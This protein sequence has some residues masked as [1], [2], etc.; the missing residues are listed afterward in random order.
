MR[1]RLL[2]LGLVAWAALG[3]TVSVER[4]RADIAFLSS[5][6][7]QGRRALERGSDVAVQFLAA[8]FAKA[9]LKP[10]ADSLLQQFELVEYRTD[11][12]ATRLTLDQGG[13]KR[14]Y[15]YG[16]GITGGFPQAVTAAGPVVFAGYGITA[17]EYGYDDY[18]GLDAGGKLALVFEYEPRMHDPR[19][20]FNGTGNTRHASPRAKVLNAQAHGAVGLL[21][22]PAPNRKRPAAPAR[23]TR[24]PRSTGGA[25]ALAESEIRIP[26]FNLSAELAE[27]L[28]APAG[29]KPAEVQAAIDETLRPVRLDLGGARAEMRVA[30]AGSRRGAS[31]NVIGMIEGSDPRLREETVLFCAHYDHNG[32]RDGK[33]LPGADDNASGAAGL[34]ELARLFGAERARPR[35]TLLFAAFGA[36]EAGLLGSYY[37]TARPPRPLAATRAV[38]NLDMIGRDEKPS[39]QTDKLI[40]IAADTTNELNLIGT[41]YSPELRKVL[42]RENGRVGLGLNYKWDADGTLNVLWRCD[43]FP[44]LMR[45]VPAVWLFNGF[46]PDYHQ[47][48][49]TIDKLN[50]VKMEKIVRLAYLAGRA[51][52][53]EERPPRF[54]PGPR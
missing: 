40:E 16:R 17:P 53:D 29:K 22:M 34:I 35:R 19:S 10:V 37:Y 45:D 12:R 28:L 30:L 36:E 18:A 46:T 5:E 26:A 49:D 13:R 3:Q 51:L 8:E 2:A 20:P 21:I 39:A 32:V 14:R 54:A 42:E 15:E 44:F 41:F 25:L 9:G 31:A 4:L 6:P 43:H 33:V 50:F 48:A 11:P 23:R 1:V 27:S 47:P 38:L 24:T 52:A 7:L